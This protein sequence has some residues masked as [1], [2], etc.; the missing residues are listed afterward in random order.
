MTVLIKGAIYEHEKTKKLLHYL[1]EKS[2]VFLWHEDLDGVAVDG[3][4]EAKVKAVVN[5]KS[6]MSG[7]YAHAHIKKLLDAGI[8]VF[9]VVQLTREQGGIWYKGEEAVIDKNELI[10]LNE[11]QPRCTAASLLPYTY[12]LITQKLS[13]AQ[14]YYS[15]QFDRFVQ[16][17]INYAKN[18]SIWFQKDPEFPSILNKVRD[19]EV[20][21]IARNTDYERDIRAMKKTL[22]QKDIIIIAVDGAADGLLKN[23]LVPDFIIGDMDSIS[24][25]SLQCGAELLCHVHPNGHSPGMNRLDQ[26]GIQANPI[27]FVGTSEDVAIAASYWSGAARLYLIGC[28]MGMR[29]FLEKGRAGMGATW[30]CRMQAGELITDLKGIHKIIGYGPWLHGGQLKRMFHDTVLPFMIERF[31]LVKKKEVLH[32]D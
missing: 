11:N 6:S 16:N 12:Q 14:T 4:I 8:P 24:E 29:E 10:I 26:L 18:E 30:L 22:K 7:H 2:I 1:P 19:R 32:H 31:P 23:K 25:K 15:E 28:R 9:D 20:F 27:R 5:G 13:E 17:T 3:L 21:I